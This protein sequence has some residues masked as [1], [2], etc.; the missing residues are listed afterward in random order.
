MTFNERHKRA[1]DRI[2]K[3][4]AMRT[5]LQNVITVNKAAEE[6]AR[7]RNEN[8]LLA[9]ELVLSVAEKTQLNIGK[10]ISDLVS[11]AL[12]SVFDDPY[13]FEVEFVQRR[14]VT[15]ADLWFKRDGNKIEPLAASGGG[16]VDI[17]AFA[18]RIAVWTLQKS[19]PTFI[20]DEPFRNLSTDKHAKAGLMLQELS[21]KLGIQFIAVSHNP[22]VIAGADKVFRVEGG[23]V[24][25]E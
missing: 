23:K 22:E 15:E 6:E 13:E 10:R 11:L 12:A 14:G 19:S 8:A 24:K 4:A 7:E 1:A 5:A 18:L 21:R 20:L 2:R 3:G 25:A 17:A 16:P 9:K